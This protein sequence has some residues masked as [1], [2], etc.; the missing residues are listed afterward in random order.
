V[1]PLSFCL[2]ARIKRAAARNP[3]LTFLVIFGTIT[4]LHK[5]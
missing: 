5:K 2:R 4:F 3:D 1:V